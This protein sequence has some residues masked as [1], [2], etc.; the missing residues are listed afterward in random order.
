MN[1]G[2]LAPLPVERWSDRAR[3]E[4]PRFLRHPER[5]LGDGPDVRPM[6]NAM[7]LLAHHPAVAATWLSFTDLLAGPQAVLDPRLRELAILRVAWRSRCSYEWEQHVRMAASVGL[8]ATALAAV[9]EGPEAPSWT[10]V[11]R[12]VVR[13][14]DD[15]V[16]TGR[17][18]PPTFAAL[19][20]ALGDQQ[21]LELL[22]VIGAYL[23]FAVVANSTG[24]Q[25][26]AAVL[27]DPVDAPS[28]GA[29]SGD[30]PALGAQPGDGPAIGAQPGDP[31]GRPPG[32]GTDPNIGPRQ[33][34][35]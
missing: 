23:C 11:D 33:E 28:L 15:T 29:P 8:D 10:A 18:A 16:D 34:R 25:I 35:A 7:G 2:T 32:G 19:H 13:A 24:L 1:R 4:L 20:E 12:A 26:D 6:P 27:A 22:F 31:A 3:Q 9:A 5:Y 17:V 21:V 14:V 30:A